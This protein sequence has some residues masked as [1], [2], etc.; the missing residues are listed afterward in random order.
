LLAVRLL[1]RI[2]KIFGKDLPLAT[3]LQAPTVGELAGILRHEGWLAHWSSLVPI[4][5]N[6]SKPPLFCV[7]EVSGNII[8]YQQLAG[9]LAPEQPLYALQAEGLD[10]KKNPL[11]RIE[12][13]AAHYIKEIQALQPEGPYFLGGHSFGGTV[14]FE[15]AQ[16]LHAQGQ[17]V[18]LLALFDAPSPI[19]LKNMP[20]F[21]YR[22]YIHRC[23][24][25]RLE[26]KEKLIY[27]LE[28]MLESINRR[29][30]KMTINYEQI[31]NFFKRLPEKYKLIKEIN[32]EA[33]RNYEPHIYPGKITL[34]RSLLRLA[35]Y[36]DDP[37]MGWG[38]LAAGGVE[39]QEVPGKH[40]TMLSE[41]HVRV[42]AEKLQASLDKNAAHSS[43][44]LI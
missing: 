29:I 9:Y 35:S 43:I 19:L 30:N 8:C 23:N 11:S 6:G 7:H 10:G 40:I 12:D 18:A 34:F 20:C 15:M 24:M 13:M 41:P 26:P 28:E 21:R 31:G 25:S 32:M 42:L 2:E 5:P 1:H 3:L 27:V 37:Q 16:Q 39:I 38:E 44:N 4:Q 17:K 14:V 36:Y 33:C 22:L